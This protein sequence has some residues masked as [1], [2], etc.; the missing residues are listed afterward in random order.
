MTTDAY[1][2]MK[3]RLMVFIQ[4]VCIYGHYSKK[5]LIDNI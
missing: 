1:V 5:I 2:S 3:L 4:G